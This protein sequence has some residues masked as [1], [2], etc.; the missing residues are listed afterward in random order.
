MP[1][2]D[3]RFVPAPPDPNYHGSTTGCYGCAFRKMPEVRCS[4]IPC[5]VGPNKNMVAELIP[6]LT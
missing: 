4:R 1:V 3:Y 5:H 6:D 2:P